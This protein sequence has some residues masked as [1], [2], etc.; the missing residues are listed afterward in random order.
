MNQEPVEGV[1]VLLNPDNGRTEIAVTNKKGYY[2]IKY[3]AGSESPPRAPCSTNYV[4]TTF[5][6]LRCYYEGQVV[7]EF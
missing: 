5:A 6:L 7:G 2:N 4:T 3:M 1:R